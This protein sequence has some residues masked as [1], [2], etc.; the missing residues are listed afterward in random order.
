[1]SEKKWQNSLMEYED[2]FN[3]VLAL[4]TALK[5]EVRPHSLRRAELKQGEVVAEPIDFIADVE[6]KAKRVLS[7][8]EYWNLL[9]FAEDSSKPLPKSLQQRLG[10]MFLRSNLNYD[11]A[12]RVLYFRAKN[13]QLYDRDEPQHFP[14][15]VEELQ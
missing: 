9:A 12:Y 14:E 6:I 2:V 4:Y 10:V 7:P 3:N 1:V 5:G 15:A 13:N 11:G 8:L